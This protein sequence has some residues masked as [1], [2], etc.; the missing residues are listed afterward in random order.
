M[1]DKDKNGQP[2]KKQPQRTFGTPLPAE[3]FDIYGNVRPD[4]NQAEW[5]QRN[6]QGQEYQQ[7]QKQADELKTLAYKKADEA[8]RNYW[9]NNPNAP[10]EAIASTR[11]A[12]LTKIQNNAISIYD[13][14]VKQAE[15]QV[16]RQAASFDKTKFSK[17]VGKPNVTPVQEVQDAKKVDYKK[18]VEADFV[19]TPG[20]QNYS[21]QFVEQVL[22]YSGGDESKFAEAANAVIRDRR[23][24]FEADPTYH[25]QNVD[26]LYDSPSF[27]KNVAG[28]AYQAL[29]EGA[30]ALRNTVGW[31][32][33]KTGNLVYG[34]AND[35]DNLQRVA[36][37]YSEWVRDTDQN[38]GR[39]KPTNEKPLDIFNLFSDP[40]G[41]IDALIGNT[42]RTTGEF[43]VPGKAIGTLSKVGGATRAVGNLNAISQGAR[44][45]AMTAEVGALAR[46]TIARDVLTGVSDFLTSAPG[47]AIAKYGDNLLNTGMI[48]YPTI[49]NK[50]YKD[51]V[52]SGYTHEQ[53]IKKAN[54]RAP[55]NLAAESIVN[56]YGIN[57]TRFNPQAIL[58]GT[59]QNLTKGFG[60][61]MQEIASSMKPIVT[62]SLG[63]GAEEF[64][65]S[66]A[67]SYQD[68][69]EEIQKAREEGRDTSGIE[70][71][72]S[73]ALKQGLNEAAVGTL[74]GAAMSSING[75]G[76][77]VANSQAAA[78]WDAFE[79]PQE[80]VE[81]LGESRMS[82]KI[83]EQ[84]QQ[85]IIG[86]AQRIRPFIEQGFAPKEQGGLGLSGPK[87]VQYGIERARLQETAAAVAQL[88]ENT[89]Q[90]TVTDQATGT[91]RVVLM[92]KNDSGT[93]TA[94]AGALIE[95]QL[96]ALQAQALTSEKAI[97]QLEQGT[98]LQGRTVAGDELANLAQR[99]TPAESLSGSQTTAIINNGPYRMDE[100]ADISVYMNDP[101]VRDAIVQMSARPGNFSTDVNTMPVIIG[102]DGQIIDGKKRIAAALA[103]GQTTMDIARPLTAP[104][105]S[106]AVQEE[107][108]ATIDAAEPNLLGTTSDFAI[109]I[110]TARDIYD[111]E[112]ENDR[113]VSE[114]EMDA[115][116]TTPA[117]RAMV[118]A[119]RSLV[120]EGRSK[121]E[122]MDALQRMRGENVPSTLAEGAYNIVVPPVA[123]E[124]ITEPAATEETV[125]IVEPAIAATPA[126]EGGFQPIVVTEEELNAAQSESAPEQVVAEEA[127]P[128]FEI[129]PEFGDLLGQLEA[130]TIEQAEEPVAPPIQPFVDAIVGNSIV[131][132]T[133]AGLT[134]RNVDTGNERPANKQEREGAAAKYN[135]LQGALA[136]QPDA[137]VNRQEYEASIIE[138]S[139][140]PVEIATI[141][142]NMPQ[143]P[144]MLNTIEQAIV[145]QGGFTTTQDSFN[146]FGDRNNMNRG[147]AAKYIGKKGQKAASLDQIAIDLNGADMDG[148]NGLNITPQDLVDFMYRFPGGV[149]QAVRSRPST[150]QRLA[151]DK[152]EQLTGFPLNDGIVAIVMAQQEAQLTAED[153]ELL[154]QDYG[155]QQDLENA[156]YEAVRRGE[157]DL[158]GEVSDAISR[159]VQIDTQNN[160]PA[161]TAV[162]VE[163]AAPEIDL[164]EV[165]QGTQNIFT[166]NA[167]MNRAGWTRQGVMA[168]H[169]R[170]K[171]KFKGEPTLV[172]VDNESARQFLP[173]TFAE[174]RAPKGWYDAGSNTMF[175]N[176]EEASPSTPIHELGHVWA[177]WARVNAPDIYARGEA[178][179]KETDAYQYA[180]ALLDG[181]QPAAPAGM[182]A[183][184]VAM[185]QRYA[186]EYGQAEDKSEARAAI[187]EE[188]LAQTIEQ[189]AQNIPQ[190]N[191]KGFSA[192]LKSLW[193]ALKKSAG[194]NQVTAQ[195]FANISLQSYSRAVLAELSSSNSLTR[196]IKEI[197][198]APNTLTRAARAERSQNRS[199]D[200]IDES[201]AIA[202]ETAGQRG[203]GSSDED[204]GE[205]TGV[206]SSGNSSDFASRITNSVG[207]SQMVELVA[208]KAP[209]VYQH[210]LN[211]VEQTQAF[212][213]A[214]EPF[215]EGIMI[216]MLENPAG[217][218]A[219]DKAIVGGLV[220][221]GRGTYELTGA[222]A[223]MYEVL[224]DTISQV[225][226]DEVFSPLRFAESMSA[227]SKKNGLTM[228]SLAPQIDPELVKM[229]EKKLARG[230]SETAILRGLAA[231]VGP[232]MAQ[233]ILDKAKPNV[234]FTRRQEALDRIGL[235]PAAIAEG[236]RAV[237]EA[238]TA[239]KTQRAAINDAVRAI[240]ANHDTSIFNQAAFEELVNE[241][242]KPR[243][244]TSIGTTINNTTRTDTTGM[245]DLKNQI[246]MEARAALEG[247]RAGR[248]QG[249]QEGEVTG[250]RRGRKEGISQGKAI[251]QAPFETAI[252]RIKEHLATA[253]AAGTVTPKQVAAI[254]ERGLAVGENAAKLDA[255]ITYTDKILADAEYD[256]KLKD[257]QSVA[258]KIRAAVR[259]KAVQKAAN[260][261]DAVKA[262][263][264]IKPDVLANLDEYLAMADRVL[265]T[266]SNAKANAKNGTVA[267]ADYQATITDIEAY[268]QSA[269]AEMEAAKKEQE[270]RRRDR[271][272]AD[273]VAAGTIDPATA[274][275]ADIQAAIDDQLAQMADDRAAAAVTN[276][277]ER[278]RLM[279]AYVDDQLLDLGNYNISNLS[280]EETEVLDNIRQI[281]TAELEMPALVKLNDV[282]NNITYNDSFTDA[283]DMSALSIVQRNMDQLIQLMK[284]TG[285]SPA[286]LKSGIA[287][288]VAGEIASI[289]LLNEFITKNTR[290]AAEL[291]RLS[292]QSE[293]F[294][295]HA[296]AQKTQNNAIKAY[297]ELVK[298]MPDAVMD[299]ENKVMRGVYALSQ[300]NF[301]EG[302]DKDAAEFERIKGLV[303]QTADRLNN[304]GDKN[305]NQKGK[306]VSDAYNSLLEGSNSPAEVEAKLLAM[307]NGADNQKIVEFWQQQ[308]ADRRETVAENSEIY[309]NLP[310]E[311]VNNYTPITYSKLRGVK[312]QT[313]ASTMFDPTF[314]RRKID[315]TPAGTK[316]RRRRYFVLPGQNAV[317]D[318]DF[319]SATADRF[320]ETNY[321]VETNKAKAQ[322]RMFLDNKN[323]TTVLGTPQ[324]VDLFRNAL[325]AAAASQ[326]GSSPQITAVER[327]I[328]KGANL[329]AAKS[330]R[331]ALGGLS[332]LPKQYVSV[333]ARALVNLGSDAPLFLKAWKMGSDYEIF[334]G[335]N[336]GQRGSTKAGYNREADF[337]RIDRS[338]FGNNFQQ[339]LGKLDKLAKSFADLSMKALI[340][341]DV[342]V[343][344]TS[345]LAFYM[346]SLQEQG[347]DIANFNPAEAHNNLN[348]KAAAYA[349]Q[350]VS[351]TQN[352]NDPSSM[353]QAYHQKGALRTLFRIFAPYSSFATNMRMSMTSDAQKLRFGNKNVR[354][355]AV[356][357]L[358]ATATE[359]AIFNTI[360]FYVVGMLTTEIAQFFAQAANMWDDDDEEYDDST[361]LSKAGQKVLSG[362]ISD[363]LSSG[364]GSAPQTAF[365]QVANWVI[366]SANG[367]DEK[368]PGFFTVYDP[369]KYGEYDYSQWGMFASP[370]QTA[371]D[372][373]SQAR[374]A[375]TGQ[376]DKYKGNMFNQTKTRVDIK[377]EERGV[378][379]IG[380]LLNSFAI[381]GASEADV[382]AINRKLQSIRKRKME[383][384]YGGKKYQTT[385]SGKGTYKMKK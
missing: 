218:S 131:M 281:D 83:T 19:Y 381:L 283:G 385:T 166:D 111:A 180:S 209:D 48:A 78:I 100:N 195:Q 364:M 9:K 143:E 375:I 106:V 366:K 4:F 303:A 84:E 268:V 308:F 208:A 130:Q 346:Q 219:A 140:N 144:E 169:E 202:A 247:F 105:L 68:Y 162:P 236:F 172:V 254:I 61:R 269:A 82:G 23:A 257:A 119:T 168:L 251:A 154:N 289:N 72:W 317:L 357:S 46:P 186:I 246:R 96:R 104:E 127:E 238:Q 216:D 118:A 300:M 85:A 231:T 335:L 331:I 95:P 34:M 159:Q 312:D 352:P 98:D 123:Q 67:D 64:T 314:S 185:W 156:Y 373:G 77:K 338:D 252:D 224:S 229:A 310:F 27:T 372:A 294:N 152:F 116:I 113:P 146:Q 344:R 81:A 323:A 88:A 347:I 29:G 133:P 49:W 253:Q 5:N 121:E 114:A 190:K 273:L 379:A 290:V 11:N 212:Q 340:Y 271:V 349:E 197:I 193:D 65:G 296:R 13:Q 348:E 138:N 223:E 15:A 191:R 161:E 227:R 93:Y 291:Q 250:E 43:L 304:S 108:D 24:K 307:E 32:N 47:R 325:S 367:S 353:G 369:G 241:Y 214:A 301:N 6:Q 258:K 265:T 110:I 306:Y 263:L 8:A 234:E 74:A 329:V 337:S 97:A 376:T 365:N 278:L 2:I 316:N 295:G 145:D 170:I 124:V 288:A 359:A 94:E 318:L 215:A 320:Y 31:L 76:K 126:T 141:W 232:E 200:A 54:Q 184:D 73:K 176:V 233:Q 332:Q 228:Y 102:Q 142:R 315:E 1:G 322:I 319:D 309:S 204:S 55:A 179:A 36:K 52:D 362:T 92:A 35:K 112:V 16:K 341:S 339:T 129:T 3:A 50:Y 151:E 132:N 287:K 39:N 115:G 302:A 178:L 38:M 17:L 262:F 7:N 139:T 153:K 274:S 383:R 164:F 377:P 183:S 345:W 350:Q 53:A 182:S 158:S 149:D 177:A 167:T 42:V 192:W 210:M 298:N 28:L 293:L 75:H 297:E 206:Y 37:N 267:N 374:M 14:Q 125:A 69:R 242:V 237:I 122:V 59:E 157:I 363:F 175:I 89:M 272:F 260:N 57:G 188:I 201:I 328:E 63:E 86:F 222:V 207:G 103:T 220:H 311:E 230:T 235:T 71:Q 171:N 80:F 160:S 60:R 358:V 299:A 245:A 147:I 40:A 259:S 45:L 205:L 136:P 213:N 351:R 305:D 26:E 87:S 22:K 217:I 277:E 384:F 173:E 211:L 134:V 284:D 58:R 187:A 361:K 56:I 120:D 326:K 270:Q 62:R 280:A 196:R 244:K 286:E 33:L 378:A 240:K 107:H 181:Q 90:E 99:F 282:I 10:E 342:K 79:S 225:Y 51:A 266:I 285:V 135:F 163:E 275:P 336:I 292:G 203:R 324:N 330:A 44:N 189:E 20:T 174:E 371:V 41:Q 109:D 368:A 343:A 18:P 356:R 165:R 226:P 333:A 70:F 199:A 117:M 313:A 249:Q 248:T 264:R 25:Q 12:Y 239:G 261:V 276:A 101:A 155:N 243:A 198:D 21:P 370:L 321:D 355:E 255:F 66:M 148:N 256:A 91:T 279:K 128:T 30:S 354:R 150:N 360:K 137:G 382:S 194:F 380:A 221:K 327:I 334:N